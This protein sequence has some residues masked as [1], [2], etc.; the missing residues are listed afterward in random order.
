M[1]SICAADR[2][3]KLASVRL[4]TFEPWRY[5]SLSSTVG[6]EPRLGTMWMCMPTSIDY[7]TGNSSHITCLQNR[8]GSDAY[9]VDSQA[10]RRRY[11]GLPSRNFG[12]TTKDAV[13]SAACRRSR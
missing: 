8:S 13:N 11:G 10:I 6:G 3:D 12:L 1:A 4:R 5:D 9:L 7:F 2:L